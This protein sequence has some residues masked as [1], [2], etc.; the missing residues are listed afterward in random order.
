[1]CVGKGFYNS[2]CE[3]KIS[4]PMYC[5]SVTSTERKNA[6]WQWLERGAP[7]YFPVFQGGADGHLTPAVRDL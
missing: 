4:L 6:T 7:D 3:I 2:V 5:T 1:M